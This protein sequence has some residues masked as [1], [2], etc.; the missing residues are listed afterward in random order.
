MG[1]YLLSQ[2]LLAVHFEFKALKMYTYAN[3]SV[4]SF[5]LTYIVYYCIRRV[6]GMRFLNSASHVQAPQ[7]F[8]LLMI[9]NRY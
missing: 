3:V 7:S 4:S 8:N 1:P 5:L 9:L 2:L 6:M